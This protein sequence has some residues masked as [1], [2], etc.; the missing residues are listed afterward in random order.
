MIHS[1]AGAGRRRGGRARRTAAGAVGDGWGLALRVAVVG[2]LG[3]RE[4][5]EEGSAKPGFYTGAGD[6]QSGILGHRP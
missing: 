6:N 1:V 3:P 5:A 2:C 4:D